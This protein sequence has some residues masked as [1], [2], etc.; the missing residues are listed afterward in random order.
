[1]ILSPPFDVDTRRLEAFGPAVMRQGQP[2]AS[3]QGCAPGVPG[4]N[5]LQLPGGANR[6]PGRETCSHSWLT[7]RM[8]AGVA[9][10][11]L[12]VGLAALA[13]PAWAAD[14]APVAP[15]RIYQT[16]AYGRIRLSQPS[17]LVQSDGRIVA[18]DAYG[19]PQYHRPGYLVKDGRIYATDAYG[20][21]RYNTPGLVIKK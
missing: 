19:H 9:S 14:P 4:S 21:V 1:M 5:A 3:P 15:V 8:P 6:Q 11:A 10:L 16:D 18:V 2:N 17:W 12:A 20:R 13:V 7:G